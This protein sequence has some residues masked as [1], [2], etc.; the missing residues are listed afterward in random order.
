MQLFEALGVTGV[1]L[2]VSGD[3]G[4]EVHYGPLHSPHRGGGLRWGYRLAR[5]AALG[6]AERVG[7]LPCPRHAVIVGTLI[8]YTWCHNHIIH[9]VSHCVSTLFI[10]VK[11]VKPA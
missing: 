10:L 4:E 8:L 6:A 3:T 9:V 11:Y 5:G 7:P 2:P 1:T